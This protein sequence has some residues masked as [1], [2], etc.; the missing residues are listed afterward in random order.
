MARR[1]V[2]TFTVVPWRLQNVPLILDAL[3]HQITVPTKVYINVPRYLKRKK[4]LY[5]PLPENIV[6]LAKSMP[7]EVEFLKCD[8]YGPITKL[9]PVLSK[10]QDPDTILFITDDDVVFAADKISTVCHLYDNVYPNE[11]VA[12][13]GGGFVVG[14]LWHP[15][16]WTFVRSWK[17]GSCIEVSLLLGHDGLACKRGSLPKDADTLLDYSC[18][19]ARLRQSAQMHDDVWISMHFEKAGVKKL[20]HPG[21]KCRELRD[22][23]GLSD[24]PILFAYHLLPLQMYLQKHYGYFRQSNHLRCQHSVMFSVWLMVLFVVLVVLFL[25]KFLSRPSKKKLYFT[26]V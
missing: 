8:D 4:M 10:E 7:F 11:H 2:V 15:K 25:C 5:P 9:Y 21:A 12:F 18:I 20:V 6:Q 22:K 3:K 17:T 1:T 19:P 13:S 14:D 23:Q 16:A 24:N 26:D